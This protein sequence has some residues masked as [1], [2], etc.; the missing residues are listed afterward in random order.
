LSSEA[1]LLDA[2][3]RL[4]DAERRGDVRALED[5]I[6]E[7]YTGYDPLGRVQDRQGVLR[8]YSDGG[9]GS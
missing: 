4:S 3:H 8:A 9:V 2:A 5:L 7:D 6:G 1:S